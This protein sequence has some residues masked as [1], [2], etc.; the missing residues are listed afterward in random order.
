MR[1]EF[2]NQKFGDV[3]MWGCGNLEIG[4]VGNLK[5]GEFENLKIEYAPTSLFFATKAQSL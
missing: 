4:D 5:I 1:G 3:G 2:E